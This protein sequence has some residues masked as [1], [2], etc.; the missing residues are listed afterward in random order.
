CIV[1]IDK[2]DCGACSEHCPTKAVHMVPY[3]NGLMIP[4]V[5]PELCIGCGACE[6]ACPTT[7]YKA[8]YVESNIVHQK[9]VPIEDTEGPREHD[10]DE[11]PF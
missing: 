5:R 7:P 1:T 10:E 3:Q 4:E 11:F 9:A 8:I 6:F 2:T